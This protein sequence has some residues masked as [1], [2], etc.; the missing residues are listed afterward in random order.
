MREVF[1]EL[2]DDFDNAM[3]YVSTYGGLALILGFGLLVA[4]SEYNNRLNT[5]PATGPIEYN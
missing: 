3:D 2:E 5:P 1:D 4:W